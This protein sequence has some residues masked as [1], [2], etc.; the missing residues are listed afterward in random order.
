MKKRVLSL[1]LLLCA[2]AQLAFAQDRVIR[3]K[4]VDEQGNPQIADVVT[5]DGRATV[6]TDENG[7]FELTI[8]SGA[9]NKLVVKSY[10]NYP[11]QTITLG[12]DESEV[13]FTL[14]GE[15]LV[16]VVIEMPYLKTTSK[17]YVGSVNVL[18]SEDIKKFPVD[19][20]TKM[21]EGLTGMSTTNAGGQP[22]STSGIQIRGTGSISGSSAPLIVVDGAVYN[23]DITMINPADI[24]SSVVL[25]DAAATSLYG[26]RGSNGVIVITTKRGKNTKNGKP[27]INVD[28]K[29]GVLTQGIKNYDMVSDPGEYYSLAWDAYRNA[30]ITDSFTLDW[31][32]AGVFASTDLIGQLGG[33]NIYDVPDDQVIDP[34]TGKLKEGASLLYTPDSWEKELSRLGT[35][36]DYVI[37]ASGANNDMDY[38][39][40]LGYRND[41]G[42]TKFTDN[43]RINAR[44][45]I[46]SK[47]LD[48]AKFGLNVN[49]AYSTTNF[50]TNGGT[51]GGYNP[52]YAARTNPVIYPVYYRNANGEKEFDPLTGTDKFDWGS[53]ALYP[54]SS[55]GDRANLMNANALGALTLDR[56]RSKMFELFAVPYL[57]FNVLPE[58]T[59]GTRIN[60]GYNSGFGESYNN[61]IYGQFANQS[62]TVSR[63]NSQYFNYTWSQYASYKRRF[64]KNEMHGIDAYVA[65]ESYFW[66]RSTMSA[67]RNGVSF[68]GNTNLT[69]AAVPTGSNSQDDN[70]RMESYLARVDYNYGGNLFLNASYRTDGSSKFSPTNRWGGFW[71][72]GAAYNLKSAEFLNNVKEIDLLKLKVSYG[73]Q[74]N[75]NIGIY[76]WQSLYSVDFANGNYSGVLISNIGNKNLTWEKQAQINAGIDFALFK[77]FSGELVYF[78][79]EIK[80]MLYNLPMAPSTGIASR[81][82]NVLD[83]SNHGF[84]ISL[85]ALVVNNK[86][87]SWTTGVN[88]TKT[89]NKI[90]KMPEQDSIYNGNY[91]FVKGHDLYSFFLVEHAGVDE[92]GN[93]LYYTKDADGQRVT[94][95]SW[96]DANN[97]GRTI[98]G[99]GRPDFEGSWSNRLSFYGFDL[100]TLVTFGIGGYVYDNIYQSLM[101]PT[102][103]GWGANFHNDL[104]TGNRW[105]NE[106]RTGATLPRLELFNSNNGATST[107]F[108]TD[109]SYLNIRTI[110]L[111]YSLPTELVSKIKLNNVRVFTSLD[112]IYLF[113]KRQGL[114]PQ[115][116]FGGASDFV[117][118]PARTLS[119]GVNIGL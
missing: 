85:N 98:V 72:V 51:S 105:T 118:Y 47:F 25:K 39:M 90:T 11:E 12:P 115:A 9:S 30:L 54:N 81:P 44:M 35:M 52:F 10:E 46:N 102:N 74:G 28:I 76:A 33:Y 103:T 106:N 89:I 95:T 42:F 92:D 16:E 49:V 26:S 14:G 60:V 31:N 83:M 36:Q 62:G 112:N 84:E 20:I 29:S 67:S 96:S 61:P 113:T 1:A 79:R 97:Y 15:Q 53:T 91:L 21:F 69:G 70:I 2:G 55:I 8:P 75:D 45:N 80:D 38:Y 109:A 27:S 22:G 6:T 71:A 68:P 66:T 104:I 17:D 7:E 110:T 4:V 56:D 119:F 5:F 111:G 23:G 18:T 101:G 86:N 88:L 43:D 93:E 114:N 40:S 108:L 100:Q 116:S 41:K 82:V 32:D 57:E 59:V 58:L 34:T 24:E 50:S 73:A 37:S 63:S 87:V 3:G 78:N 94:T 99:L 107:R 65:H 64:G 13:I 48:V 117:Y 77:R 19:N